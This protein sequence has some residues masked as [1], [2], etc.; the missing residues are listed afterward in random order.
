MASIR[1]GLTAYS[2]IL[3]VLRQIFPEWLVFLKGDIG[4]PVRF[5]KLSICDF[6]CSRTIKKSIR[7]NNGGNRGHTNQKMLKNLNMKPLFLTIFIK[8]RHF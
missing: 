3:A 6:F 2:F 7:E 1:W 8:S 4:R 5:P